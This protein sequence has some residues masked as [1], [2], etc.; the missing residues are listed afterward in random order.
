MGWF[1][2]NRP[3]PGR[4]LEVYRPQGKLP[5]LTASAVPVTAAN[6]S[7]MQRLFQPWQPQ[8]M[9][10]YDIIGEVRFVANTI[11]KP[12]ER[13]KLTVSL[14]DAQGNVEKEA[15]DQAQ[16][17]LERV[18]D[19]GGGRTT[20]MRKFGLL[21]FLIG[22]ARLMCTPDQEMPNGEKWE[23]VSPLELRVNPGNPP[24]YTRIRAPQLGPIELSQAPDDQFAEVTQGVRVYRFWN[25]HPAYTEL[26]D[27]SMQA[28]IS[29][30]QELL[31]LGASV[32][33]HTRNR[34]AGSGF[35]LIP[36]EISPNPIQPQEG[37]ED[38]VSDPFLQELTETMIASL[39]DPD[40]AGAAVPGIIRGMAES[41]KEVRHLSIHDPAAIYPQKEL[42]DECIGRLATGL[43]VPRE[44]LLGLDDA[45]HWTGW[46]VAEQTWTTFQQ[47]VVQAWCDNLTAAYLRRAAKEEGIADWARLAVTFDPASVVNHPDRSAD[48]RELHDRIVISDEALRIANG[49][50]DDD[51]PDEEEYKKRVGIKLGDPELAVTGDLPEPAPVPEALGGPALEAENPDGTPVDSAADAEKK[52]PNREDSVTE[53]KGKQDPTVT[54][55]AAFGVTRGRELAGARVRSR[56]NGRSS[57]I[58]GVPNDQVCATVGAVAGTDASSLVAGAATTVATTLRRLGVERAEEIGLAVEA[59]AAATLFDP[60]PPAFQLVA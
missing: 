35:L 60:E 24:T 11:A 48:A 21:Y 58:D 56:M 16:A 1:D 52:I 8:A 13:V 22:E 40:D 27:A 51:A 9:S 32:K 19:P 49:F 43:D 44:V 29:V 42:R 39:K 41:L 46:Q 34:I 3:E 12:L 20:M 18:Q 54:A 10:M 33:A 26:A 36:T 57:T 37:D 28:C 45:N 25:Q 14:L 6:A 55:A 31:L 47:P 17:L 50:T 23:T 59:H 2:R 53:E 5:G 38:P 15:D 30:C 4:G 7:N